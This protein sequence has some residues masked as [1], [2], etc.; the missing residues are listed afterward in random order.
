V[1]KRPC[2]KCGRLT[3]NPSRCDAHQAEYLATRD[4]KRGSGAQ[5]GYDTAWRKLAASIIA[6]HRATVGNYCPGYGVASHASDALTVDHIIPKAAGGSDDRANLA[7][8]C[9]GCNS[10]K[11]DRLA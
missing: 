8:L 3:T 11:R 4:R 6:E 9:R 10:R 2:L 5:R 7:V 1:P